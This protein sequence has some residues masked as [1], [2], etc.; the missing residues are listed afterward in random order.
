MKDSMFDSEKND[1]LKDMYGEDVSLLE[2]EQPSTSR[3][4]SGRN[5]APSASA[6]TTSRKPVPARKP[7]SS[8]KP[9]AQPWM[10]PTVTRG[11]PRKFKRK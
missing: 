6:K 2:Q 1:I 10:Q 8:G 11:Q 4:F 3:S 7:V 9:A 5:R